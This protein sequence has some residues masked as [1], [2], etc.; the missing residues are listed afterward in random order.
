MTLWS[1]V[2]SSRS[3]EDRTVPGAINTELSTW[4]TCFLFSFFLLLIDSSFTFSSKGF[5]KFSEFANSWD[6]RTRE[7]NTSQHFFF[8]FLQKCCVSDTNPALLCSTLNSKTQLGRPLP[9]LPLPWVPS[10]AASPSPP[11]G[12]EAHLNSCYLCSSKCSMD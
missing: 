4:S 1:L 5:A 3:S 11:H 10:G 6:L 2:S 9:I 12:G 8:F 7:P